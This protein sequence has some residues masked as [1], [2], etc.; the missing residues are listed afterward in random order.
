[1]DK[2]TTINDSLRP[3]Y[4]TTQMA[5]STY[6]LHQG[7]PEKALHG[8]HISLTLYPETS[9][10]IFP[11]L[12]ANINKPHMQETMK[13]YLDNPPTWWGGF[14]QYQREQKPTKEKP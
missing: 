11:A 7:K 10:D 12:Y 9:T 8:W 14:I 4:V 6:W 2:L 1:V 13:P 3:T 5:L